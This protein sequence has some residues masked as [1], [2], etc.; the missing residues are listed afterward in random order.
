MTALALEELERLRRRAGRVGQK[1]LTVQ[2]RDLLALIVRA[3]ERK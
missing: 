2:V 3:G 1:R